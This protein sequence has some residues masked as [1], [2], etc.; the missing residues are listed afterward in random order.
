MMRSLYTAASGMA[1]QQLNVDV[2][3][4]NLANVNTMGYKKERLEFQSLLYE[5]MA[6][7]NIDENG[8]G[9]P[10]N[11][12]V[13]HGV[14]PTATVKSFTQGFVEQTYGQ[15]DFALDGKGFMVV[16]DV[17]GDEV[18]TRAGNFKIASINED[19][20]MLVTTDGSPVLSTED[21]PIIFENNMNL[22]NIT[23]GKDGSFTYLNE[24]DQ[25]EELDIQLKLVQF[26]NPQGLEAIGG[27]LFKVTSASGQPMLEIDE[28]ELSKTAVMQG[29]IESSNVNVVDEMVKMIVA[30]RAYEINS[31]SIK[32]SDEMLQ[33]ANQLKR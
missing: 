17:N 33:Q 11:M 10:V 4:N 19:E 32:A 23:V 30:Q 3:S 16:S 22:S 21:E 20:M 2:I 15:F 5:T 24:E 9:T 31:Q 1:T 7:A 18:Y 12:Q 27:N 14:R 8:H 29:F 25:V 6:K 28:D 13:G 26:N